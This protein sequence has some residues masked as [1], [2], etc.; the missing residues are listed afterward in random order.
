VTLNLFSR[1]RQI[2]PS[3]KRLC[4]WRRRKSSRP[5]ARCAIRTFPWTIPRYKLPPYFA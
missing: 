4:S 2:L 1:R 3:N 5:A